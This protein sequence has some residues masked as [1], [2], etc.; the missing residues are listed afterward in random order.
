MWDFLPHPFVVTGL[1]HLG[2][3][4]FPHPGSCG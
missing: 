1:P 3:G 4:F 2:H